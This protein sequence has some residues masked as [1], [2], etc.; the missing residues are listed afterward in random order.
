MMAARHDILDRRDSLR[1]PVLGSIA[2]HAAVT[3]S[4]AIWAWLPLSEAVQ[5]GD[6]N[7]LGGG[8]VAITPVSKIPLPSRA[9][10]VNPVANDTDSQVPAP[11]PR[12]ARAKPAREEEP[13]AIPLKSRS[14]TPAARRP[15]GRTSA[16]RATVERENQLYT[17]GGAAA[18]SPMFGSTSGGGSGVGVG[19]GNPFGNRFG[20]Y[21]EILRQKVAQ[22]WDTG[23]VDARLQTAPTVMVTFEIQRDGSVRNVRFLQRS[24]H[25]A[26]DFSAQRA[27][28]DASPFPPLPAQFERE[29]ARIEFWFELKR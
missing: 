13:D 11:P 28:M 23:Q 26:L 9:G 15:P 5:W 8:S 24:G 2:L 21:A 25:A 6:P 29:A 3:G 27:I 4:L 20:W 19:V 10:P 18:N 7:S 14:R 22:A 16:S 12:P 17:A 1:A